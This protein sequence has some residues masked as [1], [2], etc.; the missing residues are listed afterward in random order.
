MNIVE[1]FYIMNSLTM[2]L[3]VGGVILN[4]KIINKLS[5]R[6]T[7][8]ESISIEI[9]DAYRAFI[10]N[11]ITKHTALKE[12]VMPKVEIKKNR[13]AFVKAPKKKKNK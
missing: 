13:H 12:P 9:S 10:I 7:W 5:A 11:Q 1:A 6:L 8:L 2:V 4:Q 3:S